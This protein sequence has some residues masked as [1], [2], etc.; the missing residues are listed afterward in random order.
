MTPETSPE[1]AAATEVNVLDLSKRVSV[2]VAEFAEITGMKVKTVR[3]SITAGEISV[4]RI[5][6]LLYIPVS[7]V[8]RLFPDV[9]ATSD[10]A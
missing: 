9:F 8:R 4:T 6:H 5:G 10:A 2:T 1:R 7:E 3:R